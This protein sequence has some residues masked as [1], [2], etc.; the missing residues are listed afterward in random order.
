MAASRTEPQHGRRR[1]NTAQS[2]LRNLPISPLKVGDSKVLNAWVHE[3]ANVIFNQA[4]WPGV[5]EGDMLCVTGNNS[6]SSSGFLFIAAK[7]E[8]LWK[9]QLQVRS[10]QI[11][12]QRFLRVVRSFAFLH[13]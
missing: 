12:C 3:S 9:Q 4:W 5:A 7:E 8:G 6:D 11:R 10:S 13:Q 2:V 1:S